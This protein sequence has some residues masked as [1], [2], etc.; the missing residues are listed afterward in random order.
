MHRHIQSRRT[1]P[2]CLA[3]MTAGATQWMPVREVHSRIFGFHMK[4]SCGTPKREKLL[5]ILPEGVRSAPQTKLTHDHRR[6]TGPA[7]RQ[8]CSD[9]SEQS[10]DRVCVFRKS[11]VAMSSG[12][13][14]VWQRVLV[15]QPHA[16]RRIGFDLARANARHALCSNSA[17]VTISCVG[18]RSSQ[19]FPGDAHCSV[20]RDLNRARPRV[21]ARIA[22]RMGRGLRSSGAANDHRDLTRPRPNS[23]FRIPNLRHL[24]PGL[25]CPPV[26]DPQ[27]PVCLSCSIQ[28]EF[29]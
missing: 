27:R 29:T 24:S 2:H 16:G 26:A 22:R 20:G 18:G 23:H 7:P 17:A 4:T 9:L 21:Y 11:H 1:A 13:R 5:I 12:L 14:A 10:T 28:G 6:T 3:A 8:L 25:A 15:A 19:T